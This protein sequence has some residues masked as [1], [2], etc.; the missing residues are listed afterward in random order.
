MTAPVKV[1]KRR[2]LKPYP[3]KKKMSEEYQQRPVTGAELLFQLSAILDQL[4]NRAEYPDLT[5]DQRRPV[6]SHLEESCYYLESIVKTGKY[7][8]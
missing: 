1:P 7:P 4:Y 2:R 8:F 3:P 6:A 5:E